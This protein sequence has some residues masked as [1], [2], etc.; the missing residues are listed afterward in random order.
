MMFRNQCCYKMKKAT[1]AKKQTKT[2]IYIYIYIFFLYIG[3]RGISK[4]LYYLSY[5]TPSC[6][7]EVQN[8]T[9]LKAWVI[10][11]I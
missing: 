5:L 9:Q 8:P 10:S 11:L 3:A 4:T 7:P 1:I 2:N 6:A